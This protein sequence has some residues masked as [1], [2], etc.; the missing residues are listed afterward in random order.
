MGENAVNE[1]ISFPVDAEE[2]ETGNS[3]DAFP[4][5]IRELG[6]ALFLNYDEKD[7]NLTD[8]NILGIIRCKVVNDYL[9]RRYGYRCS[10]LDEIVA[11]KKALVISRNGYGITNLIEAF[12]AI[13]ASFQQTE[14][15]LGLGQKLLGR[16]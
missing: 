14:I 13:Q 15:P 12:K 10:S 4:M 16:R 2:S 6:E 7:S 3:N 1:S 8:E 11:R 9:Q 5:A